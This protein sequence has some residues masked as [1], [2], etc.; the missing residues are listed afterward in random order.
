MNG[1]DSALWNGLVGGT[2]TI[3]NVGANSFEELMV[4]WEL[5]AIRRRS[6]PSNSALKQ[7]FGTNEQIAFD[8]AVA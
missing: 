7:A 8:V 4:S 3:P 1:W 2:W 5:S 6:V